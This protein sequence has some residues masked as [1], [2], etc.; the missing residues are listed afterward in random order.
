MLFIGSLYQKLLNTSE[1]L[2]NNAVFL[3]L[4]IIIFV[5]YPSIYLR[6]FMKLSFTNY[7]VKWTLLLVLPML[8]FGFNSKKEILLKSNNALY[9]SNTVVIKLKAKPD[10]KSTRLNASHLG[11]S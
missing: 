7:L 8:A 5:Y 11:I 9:M 2:K 3:K 10:R 4:F 6:K 1:N